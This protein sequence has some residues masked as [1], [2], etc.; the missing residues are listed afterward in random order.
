MKLAISD[1][2]LLLVIGLIVVRCVFRGFIAEVFSFVAVLGGL[3]LA[4]IFDGVV[5][6]YLAGYFESP[7]FLMP[8]AFL[9]IFLVV[10]LAAKILQGFLSKIFSALRLD[11]L[12]RVLGLFLGVA[13][14]IL[15]V[16]ALVYL[17]NFITASWFRDFLDSSRVV[18][19]VNELLR[20]VP[21]AGGF[22]P[23]V[24]REMVMAIN[25]AGAGGV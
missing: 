4:F 22:D 1:L 25:F 15:L 17:S 14:G 7:V 6:G 9:I 13:E 10:Y 3:I 21:G 24:L 23:D 11:K 8:A 12:D 20:W 2:I 16:V 18:A 5:A 19:L